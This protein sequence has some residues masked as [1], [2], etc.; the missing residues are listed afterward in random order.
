MRTAVHYSKD[1]F[2]KQSVPVTGNIYVGKKSSR[3]L[4]VV[5]SITVTYPETLSIRIYGWSAPT[6]AVSFFTRDVE[7]FG[8]LEE[9]EHPEYANN[10]EEIPIITSED[11]G[12]RSIMA[13]ATFDFSGTWI[14]PPNVFK[15]TVECWG[16][17]GRGGDASGNN[18]AGGGGGGGGYSSLIDY[19]VVPGNSYTV[20]VG[21]GGT[22]LANGT[23]THGSDSWFIN[24]TTVRAFGGRSVAENAPGGGAGGVVGVGSVT[25]IGGDGSI[26]NTTSYGGGGGSSGGATGNGTPGNLSVGGIA[27]AGGGNGGNGYLS[28]TS[29]PSGNGTNGFTPGGGGGGAISQT[30]SGDFIGGDGSNGRVVITFCVIPTIYNVTGG[31]SYCANGTGVAVGLSGSNTGI[32]YQLLRNGTPTGSPI[33]GTGN[34]LNFGNQLI[35][36]TYTVIAT[37]LDGGC[38]QNMSGSAVVVV[39]PQPTATISG[40]ITVCQNDPSP[41]ITFTGSNG[42]AP[43]TFNYRIN[44]GPILTTPAGNPVLV[45]VPTNTVGTFLYT[46]VSVQDANGCSRAVS[47]SATVTVNPDEPAQPGPITGNAT[48]CPLITGLQYSISSVANATSYN[49]SVPAGWSI[50]AGA[51]TTTITVTA[52]A[53]GQNGDITVAAVNSCGSSSLRILAVTVLPG[54]PAVPGVITGLANQ[55]PNVAGQVYSIIAVP[56]ATNYLWTVPTGWSITDG[57]GTASITVTTGNSG[58]N[59]NITVVASNSCGT[60][61]PRSLAVSVGPGI[62]AA[63]IGINGAILQCPGVTG[64]HYSINSVPNATS[65]T[66]NVPFGWTITNGQGTLNI[67]VT[68]GAFGNNGNITVTANNACGSSSQATLAVTV[69]PGTPVTPGPISGTVTQCGNLTGQVYSIDPVTNATSYNWTVPSGWSITAGQ[70]T[71]SITVTTGLPGQNGNISVMAINSCGTSAASSL[72]VTVNPGAPATPGPISGLTNHCFQQTGQVYSVNPVTNATTYNWIVP[73]GW[74]ITAG[75][76]TP[77]ITVTTGLP[78]ENGNITVSAGNICGNSAL[79]SLAVSVSTVPSPTSP[80]TPSPASVCQTSTHTFSV[81]SV[82]GVTYT[83]AFPA[84]WTIVSGQGTNQIQVTVGTIP[85]SITVTPSN[86][87]GNGSTTSHIVAIDPLPASVG[88]II[89]D[90]EFCQKTDHTYTVNYVDG[91]TYNWTVP[92]GWTITTGQGTNQIDVTV[93]TTG[94]S[95]QV[96]VTPEN[97]CGNGP[98]SILNVIVNPLPAAVTGPSG[99]ICKGGFTRIGAPGVAGNTYSWTSIP[100][101]FTSD[102]PNPEVQPFETTTYTLVETNQVTGCTNS[103]NVTITTNQQLFLYVDPLTLTICPGGNVL[104]NATSNIVGTDFTWERNNTTILTGMGQTGTGSPITGTL[105]STTPTVPETSVFTITARSEGANCGDKK[106]VPVTVY[107]NE[108]PQL[109]CPVNSTRN[110]D[111]GVCTYTVV[112]D[113]FDPEVVDNCNVTLTNSFNGGST[114]SDAVFPIGDTDVR[115]TGTDLAGNSDECDFTVTINDNI[116]PV[117]TCTSN[118]SVNVNNNCQYIHSGITWNAT[119]TDNCGIT[120]LTYDLAGVTTGT[121]TN[122]DNVSFN[123]GVTTVTW[124]ASDGRNTVPCSF[125]VTVSDNVPPTISCPGNIN[126]SADPTSCNV[127]LSVPNPVAGDN[128]TGYSISWSITGATTDNGTGFVPQPY[129][130]NVGT[131]TINYIITDQTGLTE[132]CSFQVIV[133]DDTKPVVTCPSVNTS[134]PNNPNQCQATLSF[135][136]TATD[137]CLVQNIK[138]YVN[139]VE[140]VFPY[141]F[142]VGTTTVTVIATDVNGNQSIPCD[143]DVTVVDSQNPEI[144]CVPGPLYRNADDD[145]CTYVVQGTEF[146]PLSF[147]D[148]CPGYYIQ[149]EINGNATLGGVVLPQGQNDLIWRVTDAAGNYTL[150][151]VTVFVNDGEAPVI[152]CPLNITEFTGASSSICGKIVTWAPATAIDNCGNT[153]T[154]TCVP[155][156]GSTFPV[157]TTT[158]TCSG[159]DGSSNTG[160]CTFTVT[161]VDNTPPNFIVP[162]NFTA[163]TNSSCNY[164]IDPS[165]TGLPSGM[166]DNCGLKPPPLSPTYSDVIQSVP[167][168][169]GQYTVTRTWRVTDVNNNYTD[170]IQTITIR[171]N[172]API[173]TV[174]S[175]RT[176]DCADP[177]TAYGVATAVDNCDTDPVITYT[178]A[179]VYDPNCPSYQRITRTWRAQDCSGNFSTGVQIITVDDNIPPVITNSGNIVVQCPSLIPPPSSSGFVAYDNCGG[180]TF[181]FMYDDPVFPAGAIGYCPDYIERYFKAI[182][183]CGNFTIFYQLI[184]VVDPLSEA[185]EC[186]ECLTDESNYDVNLELYPSVT[187]SN[188]VRK[189]KCCNAQKQEDCISFNVYLPTWAVGVQIQVGG[190]H[191]ENEFWKVDCELVNFLNG[192]FVCLPGG[193][194]Y[195]FTYCKAGNNANNTYTFTVMEGI[196]TVPDIEARISCNSIITANTNATTVTWHSVS[197]GTYGQYDGYITCLNP[198]CTQVQFTPDENAPNTII[199]EVCGSLDDMPCYGVGGTACDQITVSILDAIEVTFDVDPGAYCQS[200]IPLITATVIPSGTTYTLQWFKQPDMTTVLGTGYSYQP[201]SPGTYVLKVHDTENGVPCP[202]Y[203]YEFIVA[204]DDQ[205]PIITPPQPLILECEDPDNTQLIADWRASV[206]AIDDHTATANIVFDDDYNGITQDCYSTV[207]VTFSA[208][209]ECLNTAYATSTITIN[210]TQKPTWQTALNVLD[211]LLECKDEIGL[212]AAQLL[213]PTAFDLCDEDVRVD[214]TSGPFVPGSCPQS[215]TYTN[216][217]IAIDD[218]GNESATVYTQII[219]VNDATAPTW[220]TGAGLLNR[221]VP[222]GDAAGLAAAQ[223]LQPEAYDFCDPNVIITKTAGAQ[224][225]GVCPILYTITNTFIAT[226]HCGNFSQVYTQVINVSDVTPPVINTQP[227]NLTVEC[228]GTGNTSQLNNWLSSNGGATATDLCSAVTWTNNFIELSDLCGATGTATVIFT[229]TDQCNNPISTNAVTFTIIDTQAPSITCPADVLAQ[230]NTINCTVD[231]VVLGT[232]TGSD[233]CSSVTFTNDHPSPVFPA[234]VTI[235]TWTATDECGNTSTC[236]QRVTVQDLTPP[237]VECPVTP[238]EVNAD[239]GSCDAYVEVPAPIVT[240]PCPYTMVNDYTLTSSAFATYPVGTTIITWTITGDVSGAINECTQTVIVDDT[241]DPTISC[242]GNQLFTAPAPACT[243]VVTTIPAPVIADNCDVANLELTWEKIFGGVTIAT[244]TGDVNGT[245]F[246]V[247]ITTVIYT[248]TDDAGNFATCTFTVTVDDEVP[249]T[250]ITCPGNQTL[251]NIPGSCFANV[252]I[253]A[254]EVIDPCGEIVSI[255]H[256]SPYSTDPTNASGQYQ[257]GVTIVIWTFTDNS[258]N[259]STCQHTI[260]VNDTEVPTIT[261]PGSIT[262]EALPP[263]CSVPSI[264]IDPPVIVDNCPNPI[265]TWTKTGATTGSG[266]GLVNNTS[267]N[268]GI[269]TVRYIITD[270]SG[271]S[272]WCEF[273]VTVLDDLPPTVIDCPDNITVPNEPGECFA[274]IIVP[275][276]EVEDPCGEIVSFTNSFNGTDDASGE[277]PVGTTTVVWTFTD[278]SNN[279]STCSHTVTVNDTEKPTITCPEDVEAI[280]EAPDC[281]IPDYSLEAPVYDDNCGIAGISWVMTGATTGAGTGVLTIYD[282][283]VGVTIITYTVTDIHNNTETCSFTVTI[284]DEVPP[285]IIT[286][287]ADITQDADPNE[288]NT[289]ILAGIPNVND[290]CGEIVTIS[291]NSPIGTPTDPSGYYEVGIHTIIWTFTDQSG[292]SST[293][294]QVITVEDNQDPVFTFCPEDVYVEATPP[295]CEVPNVTLDKPDY[296]DNC[297]D[298]VLTYTMTGPGGPSSGT[299]FVT[300]TTFPVGTTEIIY[301]ATDASGNTATCI[302][303]VVAND[304]VPPTV[305]TCPPDQD[306]YPAIGE[307]EAQVNIPAPVVIDPCGEIVSISHDSP[308]G[309]PSD[310]SGIYPVGNYLITWTF[311]DESGNTSTCSQTIRVIDEQDPVIECPD[312]ITAIATTPDCVIP[313]Y[314]LEPPVIT[315]NCPNYTVAWSMTGRIID[316]GTGILSEYD[317]LVGTTVVTYTVT[318]A[319]GNVSSCFFTVVINDEVPPTIISCPDDIIAYTTHDLC[320]VTL[321]VPKPVV[322]DPCEEIVAITNDSPYGNGTD[323]ASGIYPVGNYLIIW[324][325]EDESGN[326][327]TCQQRIRVR[328]DIDPDLTCPE[329]ITVNADLNEVF[330]SNVPVPAP[331]YWD[332]CDVEHLS[333][334]SS[335]PTPLSSPVL[336]GI[337]IFP[338]P[339]TFNVGVTTIT[340]TA[341]D[342]NGN[343]TTCSFTVTVLSKPD[344]TCPDDITVNNDP[345]LC[346]ATLDP[347]YPTL[348]EGAEPITWTWTVTDADGNITTGTCTTATLPNCLGSFTFPVGVNTITWTASNVSGSDVCTQTVT[349]IDNEPPTIT[350]PIAPSFCVETIF[351]AVYDGQVGWDADIVP[352]SPFLEPPFISSWRRPDWYILDGTT[353]LDITATDNCCTNYTIVWEIDFSGTDPLQ[354]NIGGSGQ[355]SNYGPIV[356]WGTPLN[357]ELTHTITY[358][359]T[360]CDGNPLAP[361]TIDII[362]KPR[363]EVIKQP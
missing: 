334:V 153:I 270:A 274:N 317:F 240:D 300:Q 261:C 271:N 256:N 266:T 98:S 279:T 322:D 248:V 289:Y 172:T 354:P 235:V 346:S 241:Q 298:P 180:V 343:V 285:T 307:C 119:A 341:T 309:T 35:A 224:V 120:S 187:I 339:Y 328:D 356:L 355:P 284:S 160:T 14:C 123:V 283:E 350:V 305:I 116:L 318:D 84:D 157:G 49:W 71:T 342:F 250:V 61:S 59:G 40:T 16:G 110:T 186:K 193:N 86:T 46:L 102:E 218:C 129:T 189:D 195:L 237:T 76:G 267:F 299:G 297:P 22:R 236:Q 99:G 184:D 259:T 159:S 108:D 331:Y 252:T 126:A 243:L 302:I 219:T 281:I 54:T 55:C 18:K 330:A 220:T 21:A 311:T 36:G 226:D 287:P 272:D 200:N 315:D 351:S 77:S 7:F 280:A 209:D 25:R 32:S 242:P 216:T 15:V 57:Q 204:P 246:S 234:G 306:V 345:G 338:S 276:P 66:W 265:L 154:V 9:T 349:V 185:C 12:D 101:G 332:A 253:P 97:D 314:T 347:G 206:T 230:V 244:G 17:G 155:A 222:C 62:P 181:E 269:T 135:V 304:D 149:N 212:A 13:N 258:G 310:P 165:I 207:T 94:V 249:P 89:G 247:G 173:L 201:T 292:N 164:N 198:E 362:I 182:D 225:P 125:T 229:A 70:G 53:F 238:I 158:V 166:T 194:Y 268:N 23:L 175:N 111:A 151:T 233:D 337:H 301:T 67:T 214:K 255:S 90:D 146:D 136:A 245:T 78:G 329:P 114:L 33:N 140:I 213:E 197:P 142:P 133:V 60:S 178:D 361:I 211:V 232:P 231:N 344:I 183:Q 188:V 277:Y 205:A 27:P 91:I 227:S 30:G 262:V 96:I 109:L 257:V 134:Y 190:G 320:Q 275:K 80:I 19:T 44:G 202:D 92:S 8:V 208:T 48:P 176:V 325:F 37:N 144:V 294:T 51:G 221:N 335:N 83:W 308:Y 103:N 95:G 353:E 41:N 321:V 107:D 31:G 358:T 104:I 4:Q 138:Y 312:D 145:L 295:D 100:V 327:D 69:A 333:F 58:Q 264:T 47:G 68:S 106:T 303:Q 179:I 290:P 87:C 2:S 39:N 359:I 72:A 6:S 196:I 147:N 171:D 112:G 363:P 105:Y 263:D 63:P 217:W 260:T 139:S 1:G 288:C 131:S 121:G 73:S 74:T 326:I 45:A 192:D 143:F 286:C 29:T 191:P 137:N 174:P 81:L 50:T 11:G 239:P 42:T 313:D 203:F 357:I 324:S 128:C 130:F 293:C 85:G 168:C 127:S 24:N 348:N 113:E 79:S 169:V 28:S 319:S 215:G 88:A 82:P 291:H 3:N 38:T 141:I 210:D 316:S 177:A 360:D 117:I 34:A 170:K 323:D 52:G 150:C 228:D 199:Y 20:T 254:P 75:I 5:T 43:Y 163:N 124:F 340:Y 161:V 278:Q 132:F 352:E 65:Y 64:L 273:T 148:N 282:I 122:L 251:P 223:A 26:A 156:S 93:T 10:Q 115:W 336:D 162:A 167:P 296:T 56:N 118:Q 152:T